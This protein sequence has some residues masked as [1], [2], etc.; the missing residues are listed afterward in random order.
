MYLDTIN[1]EYAWRHLRKIK[2]KAKIETSSEIS[3]FYPL[4]TYNFC[5]NSIIGFL[6]HKKI[7]LLISLVVQR[8]LMTKFNYNFFLKGL[9]ENMQ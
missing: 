4:S 8:E 2:Y 7:M 1:L 5:N 3:Y 9:L 6:H